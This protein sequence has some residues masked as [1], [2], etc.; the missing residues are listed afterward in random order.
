[1]RVVTVQYRVIKF[2]PFF[3]SVTRLSPDRWEDLTGKQ[4]DAYEK[5]A[6]SRSNETDFLVDFFGLSRSLVTKMSGWEK[7]NL[8]DTL[9][10][11]I[12]MEGYIQYVSR[13]GR[14]IRLQPDQIHSPIFHI[15]NQR[16]LKKRAENE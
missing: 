5:L 14:T 9:A 2:L 15:V 6:R 3:L 11:M 13:H 7:Y 1:M 16:E 4:M 8:L 10:F 12:D